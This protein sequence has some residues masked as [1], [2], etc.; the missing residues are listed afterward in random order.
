M[1]R[2]RS[3]RTDRGE[4]GDAN[5]ARPNAWFNMANGKELSDGLA[6]GYNPRNVR[7]NAGW[8]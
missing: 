2:I 4:T 3:L 6:A 5:V 7:S 1:P 8:E